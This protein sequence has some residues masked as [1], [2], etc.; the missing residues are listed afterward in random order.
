MKTT[1]LGLVFCVSIANAQFGSVGFGTASP[2]PDSSYIRANIDTV[3]SLTKTH[4]TFADTLFTDSYIYLNPPFFNGT[5]RSINFGAGYGAAA[6][7]L[8]DGG[9]SGRWGWGLNGGEMQFFGGSNST[10]HISFNK[11]GDFQTTGTNEIMRIVLGQGRV[12]INTIAP[13][14]ALQVVNLVYY[15]NKDSARA[16]GLTTGAFYMS[17][18]DSSIVSVVP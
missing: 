11:G 16:H 9:V 10:N 6:I 18:A 1:I 4:I 5:N 8:Y 17:G 2:R 12:G 15:A 14:S 3:R 7:T 13:T